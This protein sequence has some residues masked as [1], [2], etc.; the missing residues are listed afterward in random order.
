VACNNRFSST[1]QR[2]TMMAQRLGAEVTSD[3]CVTGH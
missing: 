2:E 1:Y 3:F